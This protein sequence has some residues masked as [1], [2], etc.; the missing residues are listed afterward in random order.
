MHSPCRRRENIPVNR[1]GKQFI[2]WL[3]RDSDH[4][5]YRCDNCRAFGGPSPP[6]G[7]N[8]PCAAWVRLSLVLYAVFIFYEFAGEHAPHRREV[9]TRY[10]RSIVHYRKQS[11]QKRE[12]NGHTGGLRRG[13][14]AGGCGG[15][16]VSRSNMRVTH[17]R[18]VA[19]QCTS[20]AIRVWPPIAYIFLRVLQLI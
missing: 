15:V 2:W 1:S 6:P 16:R 13:G 9:G 17:E 14:G 12:I 20:Y 7:G 4:M 3:Q 8:A 18:S 10:P 11:P 5:S 19:S